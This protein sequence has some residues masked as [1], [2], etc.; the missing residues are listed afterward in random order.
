LATLLPHGDEQS[1]GGDVVALKL[2]SQ[3][4]VVESFLVQ[5]AKTAGDT[6]GCSALPP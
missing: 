4:Q 6:P 2:A 3:L 5:D 1:V